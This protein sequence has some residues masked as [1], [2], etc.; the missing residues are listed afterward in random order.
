VEVQTDNAAIVLRKEVNLS[1]Q[2]V[3]EILEIDE[4]KLQQW[5]EGAE[6]PRLEPWQTLRLTQIYRCSIED[7]DR[8]FR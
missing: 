2:Q 7:L 6:T 3:A 8:A 5:E 4:A 1:R